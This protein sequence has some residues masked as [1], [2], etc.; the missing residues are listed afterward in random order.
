[1][2]K[3]FFKLFIGVFFLSGSMMPEAS[4]SSVPIGRTL[5]K[6]LLCSTR[7]Q[8]STT[9]R[10]LP[11]GEKVFV[12]WFHAQGNR[13]VPIYYGLLFTGSLSVLK[14]RSE[15]LMDLGAVQRFSFSKGDCEDHG[16]KII[17]CTNYEGPTSVI[18]GHRVR[19]L[20]TY[21]AIE[22]TR[23]FAGTQ[24]MFLTT[25]YLEVDGEAMFVSMK[26]EPRECDLIVTERDRGD[27][28][29]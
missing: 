8:A 4:A 11:Q 19:A 15:K 20:A 18:N 5:E 12:D 9:Y 1:M 27:L 17:R 2:N 25:L 3:G 14:S 16:D 22:Q 26:Y 10:L 24:S 6:G 21:T 13:V 28:S 23:T 29:P 7:P